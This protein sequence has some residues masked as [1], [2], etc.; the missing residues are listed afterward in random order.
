[1]RKVNP[2]NFVARQRQCFSMLEFNC[3]KMFA[4]RREIVGG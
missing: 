2:S 3:Y 1:M 4:Q